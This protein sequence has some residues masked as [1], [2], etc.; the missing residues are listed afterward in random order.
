MKSS[1]ALF[2]WPKNWRAPRPPPMLIFFPKSTDQNFEIAILFCTVEN[3]NSYVFGDDLLP[4]SPWG[5]DCKSQNVIW[6]MFIYSN[7]YW[8]VYQRFQGDFF[9][10]GV[11]LR[12]GGLCGRIFLWRNISWGKTNSMK[13]VQ[14]FLALI[15]K[16]NNENINMKKFFQL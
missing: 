15:L 16:K 5:R 1:S 11:G 9:G 14:D 4:H 2:K 7:G 13:R 6:P 12:R 3:H 10:L 8:E